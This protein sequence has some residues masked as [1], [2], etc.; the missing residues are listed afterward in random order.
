MVSQGT[1]ST[2]VARPRPPLEPPAGTRAR[3]IAAATEEFSTRGFDGAK[4]DRIAARARVNKAMLYYHFTNKAALYR[5]ILRDLFATVAAQLASGIPA[6]ASPEEQIRRFIRIIAAEMARRP[7]YPSIWL[8]EMAESGQH[9]DAS[10]LQPIGAIIESLGAI[11]REGERRGRFRPAHPVVVQMGIVAPLLLFAASA[12]T[13]ARFA[14][15]L[16]GGAG[17][18]DEAVVIH[19]EAATLAALRTAAEAQATADGPAAAGAA[20]RSRAKTPTRRAL[21]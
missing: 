10:I 3:L 4:V 8:R 20:R 15:V 18:P 17:V 19:V 21:R 11:L 2:R 6:D 7:Y 13:R 16:R 1:R 12:P 14:S 9:L 5:E